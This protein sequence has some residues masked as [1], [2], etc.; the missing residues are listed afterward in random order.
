MRDNIPRKQQT[1]QAAWTTPALSTSRAGRRIRLYP[2]NIRKNR[3]SDGREGRICPLQ[4]TARA[5]PPYARAASSNGHKNVT[6]MHDDRL[7]DGTIDERDQ[8]A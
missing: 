6:E 5:K 7:L 3:R 8:R 1:L 4:R 2:N